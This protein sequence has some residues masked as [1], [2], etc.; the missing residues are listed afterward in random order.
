MAVW[1]LTE[2]GEGISVGPS[3]GNLQLKRSSIYTRCEDSTLFNT[4]CKNSKHCLQEALPIRPTPL[5]HHLP[6]TR[7]GSVAFI[8][9]I[10]FAKL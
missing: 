10:E 2:A 9:S 8:V 5:P 6:S 1:A 3:S 7:T 4:R